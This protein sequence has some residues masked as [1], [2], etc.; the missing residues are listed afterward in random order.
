MMLDLRSRHH[1]EQTIEQLIGLLDTS[2]GDCDLEDDDPA[3]DPLD[4]GEADY[5]LP[6][7]PL[8][9]IDQDSPPINEREAVERFYD[10]GEKR[11]LG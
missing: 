10:A 2:D 8:Y 6:D 9:G 4:H 1:I 3:G 7:I 5:Y 11:Y